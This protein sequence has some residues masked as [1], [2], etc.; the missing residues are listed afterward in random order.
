M[1]AADAGS[2]PRVLFVTDNGHGVGH[3][4]RMLAVA[5][6]A[7]DRVEPVFLTMS[8]AYPVLEERGVPVEYA[9]SFASLGVDR[10]SWQGFFA[11]VLVR[12]VARVRPS[13]VVLD[14]IGPPHVL[15]DIRPQLEGVQLIWCRRGLWSAGRNRGAL[16]V[17]DVFDAIVEPGDLAAGVDVGATTE[18]RDGVAM[19][20]PV[21]CVDP[22]E[23]LDRVTAAQRLGLDP[24]RPAVLLG[25]SHS[26]PMRLA[27]MIEQ[28]AAVLRERTGVGELQVFAPLHVLH[29][30]QLGTPAGA[31]V[32]PVYPVAEHLAAFDAVISTAGYNTFHETVA[33]GLPAVFVARDTSSVDDQARRARFAQLVGRAESVESVEELAAAPATGRLLSAGARRMA[34]RTTLALG[35]MRGARQLADIVVDRARQGRR[36]SGTVG[37][38]QAM[39]VRAAGFTSAGR[40]ADAEGA[41][42]VVVDATAHQGADLDRVAAALKDVAEPGLVPVLMTTAAA[43]PI[44]VRRAGVIM[45]VAMSQ[46][47]W[48][49]LSDEPF[50]TYLRARIEEAAVRYGADAIAAVAPGDDVV[51]RVVAAGRTGQEQR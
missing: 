5:R 49:R 25:L 1:T 30:A 23:Q 40:R 9:P 6:R 11:D 41:R 21:L 46:A 42:V 22:T 43:T 28:A 45:D 35:P 16:D 44:G 33:S 48:Q 39:E 13:A 10:H 31:V 32:R 24:D 38:D 2:P 3:I 18:R 36:H 34:A 20:E 12:T 50:P 26:D 15:A 47:A 19:T 7:A 27:Q 14:N 4:T 29:G 8:A 37:G 51:A 17:A